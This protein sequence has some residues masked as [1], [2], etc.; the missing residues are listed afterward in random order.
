MCVCACTHTRA[1]KAGLLGAEVELP[2]SCQAATSGPLE[3]NA[4]VSLWA[5]QGSIFMGL[6][7]QVLEHVRCV[8]P[9]PCVC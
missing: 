6:L 4:S 1:G 7:G 2:S 9:L 5:R 3:E 8:P